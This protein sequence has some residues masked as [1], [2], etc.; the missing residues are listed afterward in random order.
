M[1]DALLTL[2]LGW[3]G[4]EGTILSSVP[5]GSPDGSLVDGPAEKPID[6]SIDASS[7]ALDG[8]MADA[9]P[10]INRIF[11]MHIQPPQPPHTYAFA[12]VGYSGNITILRCQWGPC[13]V[14]VMTGNVRWDIVTN[15]E[16]PGEGRFPG[17]LVDHHSCC[18]TLSIHDTELFVL[19]DGIEVPYP[20]N[21][22]VYALTVNPG[23]F[24]RVYD[25]NGDWIG[26]LGSQSTDPNGFTWRIAVENVAFD[27]SFREDLYLYR[28]DVP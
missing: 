5:D 3:S 11:L 12:V 17:P 13:F 16:Y 6:A 26:D 10:Q 4:C 15:S 23:D 19:N 9:S 21:T 14:N 7:A 28:S 18:M 2:L 27:P 22:L 20:G 1:R 8:G 25:S 24:E